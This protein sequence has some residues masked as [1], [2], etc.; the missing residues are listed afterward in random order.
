MSRYNNIHIHY[1][2][3]VQRCGRTRREI[4]IHVLA[5]NSSRVLP[6]RPRRRTGT[7]EKFVLS[8]FSPSDVL[9]D[10]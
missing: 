1:I 10:Y 6:L 9:D 8:A 7:V 2:V 5:Y 3:C 4:D